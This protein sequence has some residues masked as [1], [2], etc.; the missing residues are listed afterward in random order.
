VGDGGVAILFALSTTTACAPSPS[1]HTRALRR[2]GKNLTEMQMLQVGDRTGCN[3]TPS[4]PPPSA[5]H[6]NT[7]RLLAVDGL[8]SSCSWLRTAG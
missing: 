2:W 1:T 7:P 8:R 3:H 6:P 5:L 4:A